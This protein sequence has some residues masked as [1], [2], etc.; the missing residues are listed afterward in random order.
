MLINETTINI[1]DP[2]INT[3]DRKSEY[4]NDY[5]I[6]YV[7]YKTPVQGGI[8]RLDPGGLEEVG[9][10]LRPG[11]RQGPPAWRRGAQKVSLPPFKVPVHHHTP[12]GQ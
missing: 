5:K 3:K 10:R 12:Y 11:F 9:R 2:E 6:F 1:K 7:N 8:R 4:A